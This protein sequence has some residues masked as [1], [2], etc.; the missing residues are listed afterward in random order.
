[1]TSPL[2]YYVGM[3]PFIISETRFGLVGSRI[4]IY[5]HKCL[6][7][8]GGLIPKCRYMIQTMTSL[9]E[10]CGNARTRE[11]TRADQTCHVCDRPRFEP[12]QCIRNRMKNARDGKDENGD[13]GDDGVAHR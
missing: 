4:Y 12:C 2:R 8:G 6:G 9:G 10:R 13:A 7:N 3:F 1:M 11:H 5:I